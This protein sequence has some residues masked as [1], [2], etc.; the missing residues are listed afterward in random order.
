MLENL[1]DAPEIDKD[2]IEA[3]MER[4]RVAIE[5]RNITLAMM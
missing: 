3:A 4:L 5:L 2:A 1:L